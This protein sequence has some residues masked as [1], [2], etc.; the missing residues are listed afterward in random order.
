M[1]EQKKKATGYQSAFTQQPTQQQGAW[2]PFGAQNGPFQVVPGETPQPYTGRPAAQNP[3]G[4]TIGGYSSSSAAAGQGIPQSFID[5]MA[6]LA[7]R[8]ASAGQFNTSFNGVSWKPNGGGSVAQMGQEDFDIWVQQ[9]WQQLPYDKKQEYIQTDSS[10][11]ASMNEAALRKRATE[12][13]LGAPEVNRQAI[14]GYWTS[15]V[16]PLVREDQAAYDRMVSGNR[17]R[18]TEYSGYVGDYTNT[19]RGNEAARMTNINET[20]AANKSL[21]DGYFNETLAANQRNSAIGQQWTDAA[22]STNANQTQLFNDYRTSMQGYNQRQDALAADN[23]SEL[24]GISAAQSARA[25]QFENEMAGYNS[26]QQGYYNQFAGDVSYANSVQDANLGAFRGNVNAAN[27]IANQNLGNLGMLT[28]QYNQRQSQFLDDFSYEADRATEQ[29][30]ALLG[31]YQQQ[32]STM[33]EADRSAYMQYLS[34]TNPLMAERLSQG[35]NQKYVDNMEDVVARYK[36]QSTPEVTADERFTAELARRKFESD[37]KSSREAVM[38]QLEGRGL[39]SGG[40]VVA[41]QQAARQQLAQDRQLNELGLQAQAVQRAERGLA[42]YNQSSTN[43]RAADDDMRQ[44]QDQYRQ[45]EAVRVGNLAQQRNNQSLQTNWQTTQRD[46]LGYDAGTQ[47]IR[48][49]YGR[50]RDVYDASTQTNQLNYG[51]D[52]NYYNASQDTNNQNYSRNRDLYSASTESNNLNY[53]RNLDL[54]NAGTTTVNNNSQRTGMAAEY[55]RATNNDNTARSNNIFANGTTALTNNTMRD[56]SVFSAG[57]QTNND[58]Y[59]RTSN[60]LGANFNINQT[61]LGNFGAATSNS[62]N[63]N[64]QNS[65]RYQGG[66]DSGNRAAGSILEAQGGSINQRTNNAASESSLATGR[67]GAAAGRAAIFGDQQRSAT[68]QQQEALARALGY[69]SVEEMR[70]AGGL[71]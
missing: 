69:A 12:V 1:P 62:Q 25:G 33:N 7:A 21:A 52:L 47:T 32:L 34:E 51:R 11:V 26:Q 10:S 22:N 37:D 39:R 28:G 65:D 61:N 48:D 42:G 53:G 5:G 31:R 66:L 67:A 38:Q 9:A 44:F 54:F 23:A 13:A 58:N 35:S 57:T 20:N 2:S 45:N 40:L 30:N 8:D 68:E 16:D 4:S 24:R 71:A 15:Q 70:A 29:Q 49:N 17:A 63:I 46:T 14:N 3:S 64:S 60:A 56:N 41:N 55:T 19:L 43:L 18:E 27:S 50:Q 6:D 59:G 36:A